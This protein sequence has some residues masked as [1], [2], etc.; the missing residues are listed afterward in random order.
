MSNNTVQV[1]PNGG[2][3]PKYMTP[4]KFAE[5]TGIP[6]RVVRQMVQRGELTGFKPNGRNSFILVESYKEL[7]HSL[8]V[9]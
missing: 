9:K 2:F 8:A 3:T 1:E 6:L 7:A 4:P 5:Y